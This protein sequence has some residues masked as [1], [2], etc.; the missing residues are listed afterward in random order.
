[1]SQFNKWYFQKYA[2]HTSGASFAKKLRYFQLWVAKHIKFFHIAFHY[3]QNLPYG[4]KVLDIG[5]GRGV[6]LHDIHDI[7]PDLKLY[8][9]DIWDVS[10]YYGE[11]IQFS[12]IKDDGILPFWDEGFDLVISTQVIEHLDHP[13]KQYNEIYRVLKTE[14]IAYI[15]TSSVKMLLLPGN[16]N[17][18]VDPTHVRPFTQKWLWTLG[19]MSDLDMISWWYN[20]DYPVN[21][22]ILGI[23][24]PVFGLLNIVSQR[25]ESLFQGWV[26]FLIGSW[27]YGVYKKNTSNK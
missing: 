2:W 27:I 15:A 13:V 7:R 17:F 1:M 8:G 20:R 16:L 19:V 9:C 22:M 4:A 18:Y 25:F 12:Q 3:I 14:A 6:L 26:H 21:G 23:L 11:G 5:C 24:F 10:E